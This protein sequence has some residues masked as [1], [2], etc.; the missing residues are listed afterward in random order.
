MLERATAAR[1]F[2]LRP[3]H[4][5]H[6]A[7]ARLLL[8]HGGPFDIG[9]LANALGRS[10]EAASFRNEYGAAGSLTK[11]LVQHGYAVNK[12]STTDSVTWLHVGK[13]NVCG[14][15][16][17][18]STET[19]KQTLKKLKIPMDD[20]LCRLWIG[21]IPR[22]FDEALLEVQVS[23]I[24][25]VKRIHIMQ[26][27]VK[28]ECAAI[29]TMRS[30][31]DAEKVIA[32]LHGHYLGEA[33]VPLI[34]RLARPSRSPR[35]PICTH[36]LAGVCAFGG[37][38]VKRHPPHEEADKLRRAMARTLC[39]WGENCEVQG[40]LMRHPWDE[41]GWE[42]PYGGGGDAYH[43]GGGGDAYHDGGDGGA[44]Y[45]GGDGGAYYDGDDGGAY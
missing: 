24:G 7:I 21:H 23:K 30:S 27:K 28:D 34:V 2:A 9:S 3:A 37:K 16:A 29:V 33:S 5:L 42:E 36:F 39:K 10:P 22:Y 1:T 40:C 35:Q 8:M 19:S 11:W 14:A 45:D 6:N 31:A 44:Y 25:P 15:P 20:L 18:L 32:T 43:D 17:P 13:C 12:T 26:S 4:E 38:C 41:E